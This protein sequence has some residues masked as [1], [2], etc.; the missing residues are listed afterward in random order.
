MQNKKYTH[1]TLFGL[2]SDQN[3]QDHKVNITNL[4]QVESQ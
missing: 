3:V 4:K 2:I 1:N